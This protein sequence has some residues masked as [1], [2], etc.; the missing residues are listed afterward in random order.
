[1]EKCR[2]NIRVYGLIVF[3]N[4][5]LVTDEFR[6]GM[7]MTKFPG[8][9]LHFGEGTIDCLKRECRE[10]LKQE[11]LTLRHFY[12]TDY[13]Q[14]SHF[15]PEVSQIINVYYL[16][17]LQG[18]PVF[19]VTDK[20]FELDALDGAQAFRWIDPYKI[21]PGLFTLPVDRVV[22]GLIREN[23]GRLFDPE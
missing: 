21:E 4:R 3:E 7:F 5:L 20:A 17:G 1:M 12:T 15:L 9:G 22:A 23:P 2:F 18:I 10:E 8:G 6:L 11:V 16:A 19:P 13:F 14:P